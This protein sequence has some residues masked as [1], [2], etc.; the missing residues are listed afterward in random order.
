ML[1]SDASLTIKVYMSVNSGA[2]PVASGFVSQ[3]TSCVGSNVAL[4][5][6]V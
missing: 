1:S 6:M 3:M 4:L 2:V 5:N